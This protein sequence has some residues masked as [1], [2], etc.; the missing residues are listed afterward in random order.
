M[1]LETTYT[2]TSKKGGQLFFKY[3]LNG[4]LLE[5]K[6]SGRE[7]TPT[8]AE[9]IHKRIPF[10]ET[11]IDWYTDS[12]HFEVVKGKPDLS[13]EN[14]WKTY[15]D[16]AKKQRSIKLW[17]KLNDDDKFNAI[18]FIKRFKSWS[19]MKGFSLPLPDT[20]LYN[21]RWLDEL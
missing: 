4:F 6:Y 20:Y 2:C 14:F 18:A 19:K 16:K 10:N 17:S 12:K 1:A 5:F 8:A 9:Y 15:D 7:L 13:F 3:D 11:K 21:K